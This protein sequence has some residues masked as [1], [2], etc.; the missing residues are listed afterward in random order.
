MTRRGRNIGK[1][2]FKGFSM[3]FL[4]MLTAQTTTPT[5]PSNPNHFTEKM[6]FPNLFWGDVTRSGSE[7]FCIF[8]NYGPA[9]SGLRDVR[10]SHQTPRW[11]LNIESKGSNEWNTQLLALQYRL[12]IST[13]QHLTL[14]LGHIQNGGTWTKQIGP[15]QNWG[16]TLNLQYLYTS[17]RAGQFTANYN[18]VLSSQWF[19]GDFSRMMTTGLPVESM[20]RSWVYDQQ[21]LQLVWVGRRKNGAR[22]AP[23]HRDIT[24]FA[25]ATYSPQRKFIEIGA[26]KALG[27]ELSGF[28]ALNSTQQPLRW[29]VN[30]TKKSWSGGLEG[31]WLRPLGMVLGWQVRYQWH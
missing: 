10:L 17:D 28:M 19:R 16:G 23:T 6:A 5:T 18:T 20:G 31:Q 9:V 22:S 30:Y 25:Q 27:S 24:P 7:T 3:L 15:E 8:R 11:R 1:W 26:I 12:L 2:F 29:G 4:P 14:G 21:L 13:K